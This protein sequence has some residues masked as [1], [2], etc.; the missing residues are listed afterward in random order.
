[1]QAVDAAIGPEVEHQDAATT[2]GLP[3]CRSTSS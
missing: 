1:V 3:G 2:S